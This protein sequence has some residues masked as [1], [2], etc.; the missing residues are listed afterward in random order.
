MV[1]RLPFFALAKFDD[2]N[3]RELPT[4]VTDQFFH[5]YSTHP[6]S[7]YWELMKNTRFGQL[8]VLG[9]WVLAPLLTLL[10]CAAVAEEIKIGGTGNGL[11]TIRLLGAAFSKT[12]P[13]MT[14]T[15]LES[16]GSS[17]AIKAVPRGALDIGIASRAPTD[18]ERKDGLLA[19]EYARTPTVLAVSMKSRVTGITRA[20]VADIYAGTLVKWPDG[21][22]IRPVLRQ[23]DDDNTK[24]LK[25]LSAGIEKAVLIAETRPGLPFA[26]IDQEAADKIE[27]IPGAIGVTTLALIRSEHRSLRA[28]SIDNLEPSPKN[29]ASGDYT[30][31][32]RFYFVT[33]AVPTA[34]V[35]KFFEFIKSAAGREV[36][37]QTGHW[38]P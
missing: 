12:N 5:N 38:I 29:G 11:G 26:V 30:L 34:A 35:Q 31:I 3:C 15:V 16:L 24:Q 17:G 9:S 18:A 21:T 27:S 37:M 14:V 25:S 10:S 36:L 7:R 8:W 33:K 2:N 32:K 4:V 19:T 22:V 23:P 20:Q 13:T 28:L 6:V 1:W